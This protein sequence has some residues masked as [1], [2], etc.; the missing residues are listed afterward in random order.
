MQADREGERERKTK[1][2]FL[3]C[4]IYKC[5][6]HK[7]KRLTVLMLGLAFEEVWAHLHSTRRCYADELRSKTLT[8]EGR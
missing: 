5:R 6:I 7:I 1:E 4:L 2:L 3:L 8:N